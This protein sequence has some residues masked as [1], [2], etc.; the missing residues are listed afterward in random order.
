M[1]GQWR[2]APPWESAVITSLPAQRRLQKVKQRGSRSVA[3]FHSSAI[4]LGK[5]R[6]AELLNFGQKRFQ[7]LE[8]CVDGVGLLRHTDQTVRDTFPDRMRQQQ[9]A[10][11]AQRN[12]VIKLGDKVFVGV[13]FGMA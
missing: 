7:S 9:V 6:I 4:R 12:E 3:E 1:R 2:I 10:R 11:P 8:R 5:Q 13:S